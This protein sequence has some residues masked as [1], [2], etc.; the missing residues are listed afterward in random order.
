[1]NK[2]LEDFQQPTIFEKE[3]ISYSLHFSWIS[4]SSQSSYP[5][6]ANKQS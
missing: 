1:M 2:V 6:T 3:K 4:F 5:N